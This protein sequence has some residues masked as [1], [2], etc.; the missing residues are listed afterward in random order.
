MW[1]STVSIF[2]LCFLINTYAQTDTLTATSQDTLSVSS[3]IIETDTV[4][5]HETPA[6]SESGSKK[7]KVVRRN[8]KYGNQVKFAIAMMGFVALLFISTQ[9]WNPN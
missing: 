2:L 1:I 3:D 7:I 8:F 6:T 9:S 4:R 5:V